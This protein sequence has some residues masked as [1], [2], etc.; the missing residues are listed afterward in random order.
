MRWVLLGLLLRLCL[1]Y[2]GYSST[3]SDRVEVSSPLSSLKRLKEGV[4]LTKINLS[5]YTGSAFH[6]PPLL[7]PTLGKLVSKGE[8]LTFLPFL[9]ADL[10][11]AGALG[12][13]AVDL[14]VASG[15]DDGWMDGCP[16]VEQRMGGLPL[17]ITSKTSIAH[18]WCILEI[19]III[20]NALSKT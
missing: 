3:L 14:G 12:L 15:D 1:L 20:I 9:L 10:L 16:P 5:P 13:T 18:V 11:A 8:Q 17:N 6:A 2:L 19:I 7:I 4:A